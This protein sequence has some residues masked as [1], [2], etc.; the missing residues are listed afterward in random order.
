MRRSVGPNRPSNL[1]LAGNASRYHT[2]QRGYLVKQL[3][4]PSNGTISEQ[5]DHKGPGPGWESR[6]GE[7]LAA[8]EAGAKGKYAAHAPST[9]LHSPPPCPSCPSWCCALCPTTAAAA[10]LQP[11]DVAPRQM[12]PRSLSPPLLLLPGPARHY[13]RAP[14]LTVVDFCTHLTPHGC[15][16]KGTASPT[17]TTRLA[18]ALAPHPSREALRAPS[19]EA[20]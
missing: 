15:A 19:S 11:K 10:I 5:L 8:G 20:V 2:S 4:K 7:E 17:T 3:P 16:N 9:A 14:R 13:A 12:C 18:L 1:H 6:A